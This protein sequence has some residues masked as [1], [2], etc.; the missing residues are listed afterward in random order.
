MV[1][2][3]AFGALGVVGFAFRR[4]VFIMFTMHSLATAYT[5]SRFG[6]FTV[7]SLF[8]P[9]DSTNVGGFMDTRFG[10]GR[11]LSSDIVQKTW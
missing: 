11:F 4:S 7:V 2:F 8:S 5:V 9:S 1:H 6:Y 10:T 3:A